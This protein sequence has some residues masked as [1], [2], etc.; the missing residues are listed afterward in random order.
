MSERGRRVRRTPEQA[1]EEILS[2]ARER[3]LAQGIEG[4]KVADIAHDVQM[5]HA[6]LLHHFGS[7]EGMRAALVARMGAELLS[8]LLGMLDGSRLQPERRDAWLA[9]TFATLADPRHGQLFAW[10][11]LQPGG[12]EAAETPQIAPTAE[13]FGQLLVRMQEVMP[14]EQAHFVVTLVVTSAIGLGVSR[15]WLGAMG[16]PSDDPAI[17]GFV[18]QL[19]RLLGP[20]APGQPVPPP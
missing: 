20:A 5:S 8:Q 4:L 7:S 2:A 10:I 19:G 18:A 9:K 16:L 6:T 12:R 11:A 1:R 15:S 13:L 3:L 17:A 14:L